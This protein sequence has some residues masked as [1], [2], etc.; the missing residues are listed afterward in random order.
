MSENEAVKVYSVYDLKDKYYEKH[1]NGHYFD[2]DTLKFFGESLST[3]NL[4]QGTR[5]ITD[6]CGEEHECYVLS[7]LQ[8]KYPGGRRRRYTYFDV[9]TLDDVIL[10]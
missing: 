5:K 10:P 1:P 8:K 7:S 3:M 4:L 6:I 9:C 2:H